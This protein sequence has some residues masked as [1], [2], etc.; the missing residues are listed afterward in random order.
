MVES[1]IGDDTMKKPLKWSSG[2]IFGLVLSIVTL[3][4]SQ[5]S[6]DVYIRGWLA[7]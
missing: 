4:Y 7:R 5:N 6:G 2:I 3:Q 1:V